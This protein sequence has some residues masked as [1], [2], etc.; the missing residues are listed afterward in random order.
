MS[1]EVGEEDG[2]VISQS[3]GK[4]LKFERHYGS[5]CGE[6]LFKPLHQ[7]SESYVGVS[8]VAHHVENRTGHIAHTLT[9]SGRWM[10]NAVP[11]LYNQYIFL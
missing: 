10:I 8:F 11:A 7:G 1:L 9:V 4:V 6:I 2:I 5:S 3:A